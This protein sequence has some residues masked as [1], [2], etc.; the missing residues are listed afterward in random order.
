MH[1]TVYERGEDEDFSNYAV[2]DSFDVPESLAVQ[3][4]LAEKPAAPAA[5]PDPVAPPASVAAPVA[6]ESAGSIPIWPFVAAGILLVLVVAWVL[7]RKK[8]AAK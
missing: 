3:A 7:I 1:I 8:K 6:P 5:E 4:G 2:I